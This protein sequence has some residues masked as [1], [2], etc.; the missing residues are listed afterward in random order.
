[1]LAMFFRLCLLVW[2]VG[3]QK[4]LPD[5]DAGG[6]KGQQGWGWVW[7]VKSTGDID[8]W[9]VGMHMVLGIIL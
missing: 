6:W 5:V 3:S 9:Q 7:S 2:L 8:W 4:V 1:M